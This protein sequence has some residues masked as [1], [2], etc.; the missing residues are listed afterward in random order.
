MLN[1]RIGPGSASPW[2]ALLAVSAAACTGEP[3]P[4]EEEIGG[5]ANLTVFAPEF[6]EQNLDTTTS[7]RR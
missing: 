5:T 7:P 2:P 4:P 1:H 6:P 3:E